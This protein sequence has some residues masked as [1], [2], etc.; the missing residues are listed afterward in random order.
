MLKNTMVLTIIHCLCVKLYVC[1]CVFLFI[2]CSGEGSILHK[3]VQASP[4]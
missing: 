3:E 1:V 4:G 2:V